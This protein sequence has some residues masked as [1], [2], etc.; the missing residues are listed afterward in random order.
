MTVLNNSSITK[1]LIHND[2]AIFSVDDKEKFRHYGLEF[3]FFN[4]TLSMLELLKN[5]DVDILIVS[6]NNAD[7]SDY[8]IIA[9]IRDVC[10]ETEII[11]LADDDRIPSMD[12]I[13]KYS[14]HVHIRTNSPNDLLLE[15]LSV[16]KICLQRKQ[17]QSME[18]DKKLLDIRLKEIH[19][20]LIDNERLYFLGSIVGSIT[21]N[22][23]TPLMCI[24]T[25][26]ESL[27]ELINEYSLSVGDPSV[28]D[29]DHRNIAKDMEVQTANLYQY[30]VYLKELAQVLKDQTVSRSISQYNSFTIGNLINRLNIILKDQLKIYRCTLNTQCNI[31]NNTIIKGK[32]ISLIQVI[33]NLIVNSAEA[34][35]NGGTINLSIYEQNDKILFVIEDFAGGIP[36]EI[37]EKLFKELITTKGKKGTGIG[38]YSSYRLIKNDFMGDVDVKSEV[39][40]GTTFTISIPGS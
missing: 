24:G 38:V 9:S 17:I 35:E 40:K 27:K 11:L 1:V 26:I 31:D 2:D 32:L 18:K 8:T 5:K 33:N 14:I 34:Y 37:K 23:K 19:E 28:T 4:D 22:M 21:H 3:E 16:N 12:I 10:P 25:S 7:H 20:T 36:E 30:Y 15:I 39:G 13:L 29:D 6:F